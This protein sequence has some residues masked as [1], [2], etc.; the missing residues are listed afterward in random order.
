MK[1]ANTGLE[2]VRALSMTAWAV[3]TIWAEEVG[4][5]STS[6]AWTWGSSSTASRVFL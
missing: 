1:Q 4:H 5:K 2:V 6:T 3:S